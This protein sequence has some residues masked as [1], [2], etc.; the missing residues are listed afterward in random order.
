MASSHRPSKEVETP[1]AMEAFTP[2]ITRPIAGESRLFR[3]STNKIGDLR[4]FISLNFS[5]T[6]YFRD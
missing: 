3:D 1:E 5:F 6:S 4:E 2:V